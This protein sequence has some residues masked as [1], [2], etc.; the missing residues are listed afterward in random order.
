MQHNT[1][2]YDVIQYN[3]IQIQI[4]MRMQIQIQYTITQYNTIQYDRIHIQYNT[5]A[6]Q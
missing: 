1:L 6:I 4:Q 5:N 3:I 2:L